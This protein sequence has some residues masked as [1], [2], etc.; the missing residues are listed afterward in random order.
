VGRIDKVEDGDRNDHRQTIQEILQVLIEHDR[1]APSLTKLCRSIDTSNDDGETRSTDS[2]NEENP[3]SRHVLPT[4]DRLRIG[5]LGSGNVRAGRQ[6]VVR[7]RADDC[8]LLTYSEGIWLVSHHSS[9]EVGTDDDE[10][11]HR[12]ELEYDTGEHDVFADI[13]V[14]FRV[15]ASCHP[16]SHGLEDKSD[17]VYTEKDD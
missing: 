2:A 15:G 8:S 10:E 13:G 6:G 14:V 1:S 9:D 3:P 17:G 4:R 5:L 7:G 16:A 12:D 11:K